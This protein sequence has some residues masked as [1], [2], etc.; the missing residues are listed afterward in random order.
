MDKKALLLK[1]KELLE[2]KKQLLEKEGR[3]SPTGDTSSTQPQ[4]TA[5]QSILEDYTNQQS[6]T[7]TASRGV[8]PEMG[9]KIR[10]SAPEAMRPGLDM[11]AQVVK[12][13][14]F[15]PAAGFGSQMMV[16]EPVTSGTAL[17]AGGSAASAISVLGGLILRATVGGKLRDPEMQE[18]LGNIIQKAAN[19]ELRTGTNP[20]F[21][22]G[23][24]VKKGREFISKL[25]TEE[26]TK[27]IEVATEAMGA[28]ALQTAIYKVT[29]KIQNV[30]N[31]VFDKYMKAV[32]PGSNNINR[33]GGIK[34]YKKNV[35][36]AVDSIVENADNL[37]FVDSSSG[38]VVKRLPES[39]DDLS[40]AISQTKKQV[41][42][43]YD[44]MVKDLNGKGATVKLGDIADDVIDAVSS[45]GYEIAS[46]TTQNYAIKMAERL[47]KKGALSL[48]E[49]QDLIEVLNQKLKSFYSNPGADDASKAVIDAVVANRLRQKINTVVNSATDSKFSALK[50]QYGA[51][52]SVEKSVAKAAF[53]D[54]TSPRVGLVDFSDI[55]TVSDIISG[56]AVTSPGRLVRGFTGLG[57]K[58]FYKKLTNPNHLVSK[59]FQSANAAKNSGN[60]GLLEKMLSPGLNR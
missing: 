14:V 38:S 16:D 29:P 39:L 46:P 36:A 30:S 8:L 22:I 21:G 59:M 27:G 11:A 34:N 51:L 33:Y 1:R 44:A 24:G 2:Q 41:F 57:L 31:E 35:V 55:F 43:Q 28:A 3:I 19:E 53:K 17:A 6:L 47:E 60:I 58:T 48:N 40:S 12:G 50:Q 7:E 37:R 42:T 49:S 5:S 26:L 56:L 4:K 13:Q 45:A 10:E 23:A 32:K 54:L 18:K 52:E 25:T 20:M 15:Q 9:R